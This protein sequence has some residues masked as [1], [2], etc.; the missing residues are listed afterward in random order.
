MTS[1]VTGCAGFIGF[2]LS[3][4]LLKKNIKVI[5]IDNLNKYYDLNLKKKRLS[6]LKK[7]KKFKFYKVDIRN[8][9]KLE[10]IFKKFNPKNVINLAAQAGVRYSLIN[11][12][13]YINNN[14]LGF[15]NILE[16]SKKYN[17]KHLVYASSSSVYGGIKKYPFKETFQLDNPMSMYAATKKSNELMAHVYSHIYKLPTTGLRFFT[18]YGP[19]GRPDMSLFLFVKSILLKKKINVFNFG[20]M[21]RDFTYISDIVEGTFRVINKPPK[22][23]KNQPPFRILNIGNNNP[24]KL[25]KYIEVIE[26]KLGIKSKKNMLPLQKGDIPASYA[27]VEKLLKLTGYK[28]KTSIE[29]GVSNFISW[30]KSYHNVK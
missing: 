25:E 12:S 28:P 14:I 4:K 26:N 19:W 6:Y 5:G 13:A 16:N 8:K 30:F 9:K 17:C 18:V 23:K 2:H 15:M 7:Y 1:L 24:V 21:K 11:P 22:S 29:K 3:E 10:Q 27:S 20:K